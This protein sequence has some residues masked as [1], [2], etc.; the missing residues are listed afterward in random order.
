MKGSKVTVTL[1][2]RKGS[3]TA[4]LAAD[5]RTMRAM[6]GTLSTADGLGQL[7]EAAVTAPLP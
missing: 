6:R 5:E 3:L 1:A 2:D 4:M 7:A